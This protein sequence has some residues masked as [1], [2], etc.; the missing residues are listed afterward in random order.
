MDDSSNMESIDKDD[1]LIRYLTEE[2]TG[3]EE[4]QVEQWCAMSDENR[5]TLEQL[6][7]ALQIGNRLKVMKS[8]NHVKVL[9]HLKDRIR[10]KN[11]FV[12]VDL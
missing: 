6:Y 9:H 8:V 7:F 1:L 4:A 3:E 2:V 5:K 12:V 11:R 10:R